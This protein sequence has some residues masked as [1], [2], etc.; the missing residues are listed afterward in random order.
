MNKLNAIRYNS[1]KV[2]KKWMY[3]LDLLAR[4]LGK[5]G[6][7][8]VGAQGLPLWCQTLVVP[9]P[10]LSMGPTFSFLVP[11]YEGTAACRDRG[12][13]SP[14]PWDTPQPGAARTALIHK[15]SFPGWRRAL[16][17]SVALVRRHLAAFLDIP[18]MMSTASSPA[19]IWPS[20]ESLQTT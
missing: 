7:P 2:G 10:T 11:G 8:R 5:A 15:S 14:S 16:P 19:S 17:T 6:R 3:I 20:W 12:S 4:R 13:G 1:Q 9:S 18:G